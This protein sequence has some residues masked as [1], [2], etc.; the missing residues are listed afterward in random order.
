MSYAHDKQAVCQICGAAY[1]HTTGR[2]MHT[3]VTWHNDFKIA[4]R[5]KA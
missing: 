4:K 3:R 1:S 2:Q 5:P